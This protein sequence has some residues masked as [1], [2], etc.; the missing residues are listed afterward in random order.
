M[1]EEGICFSPF[2]SVPI[3][4][5]SFPVPWEWSYLLLPH[6]F[7]FDLD[8]CSQHK[9]RNSPRKRLTGSHCRGPTCSQQHSSLSPTPLPLS[10]AS[11]WMVTSTSTYLTCNRL[12]NI[13]RIATSQNSCMPHWGTYE[14]RRAERLV[15]LYC[16]YLIR[17][18][19]RKAGLLLFSQDMTF[20]ERMNKIRGE[21][22]KARKE[23]EMGESIILL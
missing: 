10:T 3:R 7:L 22:Q 9:K 21:K 13:I 14:I 12:Q 11:E 5:C 15:K 20:M 19:R 1:A 16:I 17:D 4:T 23:N 2:T 8:S 18:D 6:Y